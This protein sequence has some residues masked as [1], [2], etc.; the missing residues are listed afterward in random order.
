MKEVERVFWAVGLLLLL[1][2]AIQHSFKV[3]ALEHVEAP[4]L[5]SMVSGNSDTVVSGSNVTLEEAA[6]GAYEDAVSY[7]PGR[8]IT[9]QSS[10]PRRQLL[11]R[12]TVPT[13]NIDLPVVSG[14]GKPVSE[15]V[16]LINA[17]EDLSSE[18][19]I[20]LATCFDGDTRILAQRIRGQRLFLQT[21]NHLRQYR[22]IGVRMANP[23]SSQ[24]SLDV[25]FRSITLLSCISGHDISDYLL[26]ITAVETGSSSIS[27]NT[28]L[29]HPASHLKF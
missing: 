23:L 27:L 18:H 17:T 25:D 3:N 5:H 9:Y 2:F 4:A 11:G 19:H 10:T 12:L 22:I 6:F 21:Q 15:H 1:P 20:G 14:K 28:A 24:L 7:S 16:E 29:L 8:A 26:V 13:L